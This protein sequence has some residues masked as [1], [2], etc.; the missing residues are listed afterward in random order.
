VA[1]K[2]G[3]TRDD[4]VKPS[5]DVGRDDPAQPVADPRSH[6]VPSGPDVLPDQAPWP[7]PPVPGAPP[8]DPGQGA[9]R[10][11]RTLIAALVVAALGGAAIS[12]VSPISPFR[13][14]PDDAGGEPR[15]APTLTTLP[16]P[17]PSTT[18]PPSTV[19]PPGTGPAPTT[20]P[21]PPPPPASP[22]PFPG[23]RLVFDEGFDAVAMTS[24]VWSAGGSNGSLPPVTGGGMTTI[25]ATAS[26][27][28]RWG[29]VDSIGPWS[30]G[31]PTHPQ[32]RSWQYGYFEA[33][34]RYT[35]DPWSWP[36]FWLFSS[37]KVEAM[38]GEDCSRLTS[39]W[40]IME[41]GLGGRRADHWYH[42]ALHR[43][44]SDGTPDGY[45]GTQ[46][47]HRNL[48]R[49]FPDTN[50]AD[51]HTWGARWTPDQLCTYLDGIEIQCMP[52]YDTT[53]QPMHLV[54]SIQYLGE[55]NGCP[56]RPPSL[57]MQID[58][59]RVWQPG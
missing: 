33:R 56:P 41:N 18:A 9:W 10:R 21:V 16:P 34:L 54:F 53:H 27:G 7:D 17:S 36:A 43:N 48:H 46:D 6:P 49:E 30:S 19:V 31:E 15:T 20:L 2:A 8:A 55:C 14:D 28:H 45:C 58:W 24:G 37:A 11:R 23:Y 13:S 3:T 51:W 26:N 47:E 22:P 32:M 38:P 12:P 42:T 25:T 1:R 4:V 59:V 29:L 50:L 57:E 44:T 35:D 40:D 5:E 39:E 52:P